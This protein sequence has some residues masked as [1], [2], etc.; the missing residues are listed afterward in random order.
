VRHDTFKNNKIK[1]NIGTSLRQQAPQTNKVHGYFINLMNFLLAFIVVMC[2]E[3]TP[4]V[5]NPAKK[6]L[7]LACLRPHQQASLSV[8]RPILGNLLE[9]MYNHEMPAQSQATSLHLHD[10]RSETS[11]VVHLVPRPSTYCKN[12]HERLHHYEQIVWSRISIISNNR[13]DT[14]PSKQ[15]L[16]NRLAA[17]LREE[18]M[19][20]YQCAKVKELLEGDSN[21]IYF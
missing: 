5:S 11:G 6:T 10:Q 20:W 18:E 12:N 2:R 9:M 19:K 4:M 7:G 17:L 16:N 21:T 1:L 13:P 14:C 8:D 3:S 15:Y